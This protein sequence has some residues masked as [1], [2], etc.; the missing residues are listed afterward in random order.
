MPLR[1]SAIS[2]AS[3]TILAC[4]VSL[5]DQPTIRREYRSITAAAY[6]QPSVVQI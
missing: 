1:H 3:L 6:S 2:S 4:I 5:M